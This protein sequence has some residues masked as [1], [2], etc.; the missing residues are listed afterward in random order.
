MPLGTSAKPDPNLQ[1][2]ANL[3]ADPKPPIIQDKEPIL[4]ANNTNI[5]TNTNNVPSLPTPIKSVNEYLPPQFQTDV[6]FESKYQFTITSEDTVGSGGASK[7]KKLQ[8]RTAQQQQQQQQQQ[9]YAIKKFVL[10]KNESPES[11]Y[12]RVFE[13]YIIT[14]NLTNYKHIVHCHELLNIPSGWGIIMDFYPCDLLSIIRKPNWCHDV[15]IFEKMCYFKQICFGL[16][17]LH[18]SDIV[19]RD[20]KPANVLV[21]SEGILKL[22]DFGCSDFGHLIPGNFDSDIAMETNVVL[23]TPPYRPPECIQGRQWDGFKFDY[24]SLGVILFV[25][26]WG[27]IPFGECD[28]KDGNYREYCTDHHRYITMNPNLRNKTKNGDVA[29]TH[30][31]RFNSKFARNF[32]NGDIVRI[33]WK[34]CDPDPFWRMGLRDLFEEKYFQ[35]LEMCVDE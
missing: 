19:H 6:K 28:V 3:I 9:Y 25:L 35:K 16:K 20:L 12:R 17:F 11:Y 4:S 34:L 5:N 31:D 32:P 14:K 33:F 7:I 22:T 24:W 27:R 15:P 23:G 30:L 1:Q 8:L 21:T 10:F 18:E 13:E 29:G 26:V 2:A